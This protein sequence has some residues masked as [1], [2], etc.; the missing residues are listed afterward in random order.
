[1]DR[2]YRIAAAE[3][4]VVC[5]AVVDREDNA[6]LGD[7]LAWRREQIGRQ[8]IDDVAAVL[9]LRALMSLDDLLDAVRE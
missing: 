4:S 7:T 3:R 6:A 1:M 8:G 5:D 2:S 9:E